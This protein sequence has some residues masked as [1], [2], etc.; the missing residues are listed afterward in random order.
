MNAYKLSANVPKNRKISIDVPANIPEGPVEIILVFQAQ[1]KTSSKAIIE[2]A[3]GSLKG[4]RFNTEAFLK[5]KQMD[6][7]LER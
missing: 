6:K 3:C 2:K 5:Q 1:Q 7:E 4:S